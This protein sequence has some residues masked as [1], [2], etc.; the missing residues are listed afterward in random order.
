MDSF[1]P[2]PALPAHTK[3][4]VPLTP[5]DA[6]EVRAAQA[7]NSAALQ[8]LVSRGLPHVVQWCARLGG[9]RVD[10]EDAAH[11]VMVVVLTRIHTLTDPDAYSSWLFG[12]T[13]RVLAGHRRKRWFESWIPGM[14]GRSQTDE[15]DGQPDPLERAQQSDLSRRVQAALEDLSADHREII[16]LMDVEERTE[17]E[18]SEILGLPIGT[19]RSRVH[20]SRR[21]FLLVAQKHNLPAIVF[22]TARGFGDDAAGHGGGR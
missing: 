4:N 13:R 15:A 1:L 5:P 2:V 17:R 14:P 8:A 12:I 11:D 16:V 19:V 18:V 9:P 3:V 10:P 20:R 21:A 7:G 22:E 6:N